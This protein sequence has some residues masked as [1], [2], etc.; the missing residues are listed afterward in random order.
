MPCISKFTTVLFVLV[1]AWTALPGQSASGQ[2]VLAPLR[3]SNAIV[4]SRSSA[5]VTDR[6]TAPETVQVQPE[7]VQP[8]RDAPDRDA[9]DKDAP[10]KDAPDRDAGAAERGSSA[11]RAE[12][13]HPVP[14][15]ALHARREPVFTGTVP[16]AHLSSL[17]TVSLSDPLLRPD[18]FHSLAHETDRP[19]RQLEAET[20]TPRSP[21]DLGTNTD[22]PPV[23]A[24]DND[25]FKH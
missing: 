2:I 7:R 24:H 16:L 1:L 13:G 19:S 10:D 4:S 14:D 20:Q 3:G 25:Q 8:N 5:P 6:S 11:R 12:T 15:E 21:L 9:P 22:A 18:V 23:I 17:Q